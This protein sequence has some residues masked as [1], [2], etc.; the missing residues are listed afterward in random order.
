MKAQKSN[1]EQKKQPLLNPKEKRAA[2]QLKKDLR[3]APAPF[4]VPGSKDH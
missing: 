2:K 3:F 1:K 4:I